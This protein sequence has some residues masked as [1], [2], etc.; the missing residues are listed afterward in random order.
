MLKLMNGVRLKAILLI[1]SLLSGLISVSYEGIVKMQQLAVG[2]EPNSFA[3]RAETT[4]T[5]LNGNILKINDV[6]YNSEYANGY[7]DIYIADN[8]RL[9]LRPVY[10]YLH[11]SGFVLMDKTLGAP[12]GKGDGS[13]YI[14]HFLEQGINVVSLDYAL[15]TEYRYP[16]PVIQLAEAVEW[17]KANGA[18][19]GLDMNKLI[20][21]GISAGGAIAGMFVNTQLDAAYAAQVG[22]PRVIGEGDIAALVLNSAPLRAKRPYE[23]GMLSTELMF[24]V[25]GNAF[26]GTGEKAEADRAMSDIIDHVS[27]ACCPVWISDGNIGSFAVHA[28]LL[29]EKLTRLGVRHELYITPES[30]GRTFHS[31]EMMPDMSEQAAECMEKMQAFLKEVLA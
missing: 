11:G 12:I 28:R 5:L 31:F 10:I 9:T 4:E 26:Y 18:S 29:D 19:Y 6:S 1:V 2:S 24:E 14:E 3:A 21:G 7:M 22:I 16:T 25:Y 17:L 15:A 27:A 8:D 13:G 23:S 30:E 20:V